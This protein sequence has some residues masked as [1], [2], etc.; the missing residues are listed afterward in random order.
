MAVLTLAVAIIIT[1]LTSPISPMWPPYQG[2]GQVG[3]NWGG[4]LSKDY[5]DIYSLAL[6]APRGGYVESTVLLTYPLMV[7]DPGRQV[8]GYIAPINQVNGVYAICGD[9]QL[10]IIATQAH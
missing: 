1:A 5:A 10:V 2:I 9:Y 3:I 4:S 6:L 8:I 7:I